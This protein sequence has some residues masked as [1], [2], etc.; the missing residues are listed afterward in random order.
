MTIGLLLWCHQGRTVDHSGNQHRELMSE[1]RTATGAGSRFF[2][3][4]I[5]TIMFLGTSR[6]A[7]QPEVSGYIQTEWQHFDLSDDPNDRGFYADEQKNLFLIRRGRIKLTHTTE[8]G[9]RGVFQIDGTERGVS[10]K[11]GY[12]EV[13]LLEDDLLG[14]TVGLF[15]KPNY[16]VML[17]SS[18]RESP[19]RSQVVRAFYPGER[20]LGF[21]VSSTPTVGEDFSPT[22]Q[23][24][25]FNGTATSPENDA[26]KDI[27]GR[28]HLPIPTGEESP[29][30]LGIGGL[31]YLGG[32]EQPED[33]IVTFV[34]GARVLERRER[35]GSWPGYGTRSHLGV[36]LQLALDLFSLGT[37][38]VRGE[39]LVGTM[40][41]NST[42]DVTRLIP[43]SN[44]NDSIDDAEIVTSPVPTLTLRDQAGIYLLLVQELGETLTFAAKYDMFDR[45]TEL[46]GLQVDDP[47]DRAATIL[48]IGL[49]ADFGPI[50]LTG[51]YEI[52]S[53]ATDE[54]RYTDPS[55]VVHAGDLRDNRTT[56]RFQYRMK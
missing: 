34:D 2:T 12:L 27:V 43:D 14:V 54:A 32:L 41:V 45:N 44:P 51:W 42:R 1:H 47:D 39:Y 8:E 56:I 35:H 18:R 7:A 49:L 24:G 26:Y 31:F 52:P 37:T 6:S 15:N 28:L 48:G 40:P 16:E 36:E 5:V 23:L 33:T 55:G 53:F 17:S 20:G 30:A 19:E 50:R 21:M 38:E 25:L 46:S 29:V 4:L 22:I 9:Y 11:D 13:P 10:L 3:L